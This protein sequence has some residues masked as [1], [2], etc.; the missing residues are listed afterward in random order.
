MDIYEFAMQMERD[1]EKLYRE[2]AS[3]SREQGI[4]RI[5][6]M[7]ADDEAKHYSIV[8][9]MRQ[10]AQ[11]QQMARTEV[12]T[13]AKNVFAEMQGKSFDLKGTAVELY[14]QA[15][16]I[17]LR[18]EEFYRGKAQEVSRPAHKELFLKIAEEEKRHYT[19]LDY[20][21]EFL[22]RPYEWMENAEFNHLEDY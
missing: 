9:Q 11:P 6:S 1:G 5:L 20:I 19:L 21:I 12:L 7:L 10:A 18:S 3:Q 15:Q 22:S 2:L 17:E 8:N 4:A 13:N 14:R 16:D